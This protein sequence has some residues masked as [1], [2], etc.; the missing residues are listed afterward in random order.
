MVGKLSENFA[1]FD[2]PVEGFLLHKVPPPSELSGTTLEAIV[3]GA[4]LIPVMGIPTGSLGG[5]SR[6]WGGGPGSGLLSLSQIQV[7]P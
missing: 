2:C 3:L 6:I 5:R 7:A 4:H 1:C